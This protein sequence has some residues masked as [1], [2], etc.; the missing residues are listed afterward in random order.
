MAKVLQIL[1]SGLGGHGSVAFSL[2]EGDE[3]KSLDH[4]MLFYGIEELREEY[5][6]K[7]IQYAVPFH[8]VKKKQ[9]IDIN[10]YFKVYKALK[11]FR[12]DVVLM[13]SINLIVVG[14]IYKI[15]NR[16]KLLVVEHTPNQSKRGSEWLWSIL[17]CLFSQK[18]VVLSNSYK[19]EVKEKLGFFYR[20]CKTTVIP[21]GIDLNKFAP[22]KVEVAYN[23]ELYIAMQSRL[24]KTKDH[25]T[26]I[27]AFK[28]LNKGENIVL[29]IAGGGD[30]LEELLI[31][32]KEQA[33]ED[34]AFFTGALNENGIVEFLNNTFIYVH[35]SLS[36]V[37]STSVMQAMAT[38]L[39]IIAS[40]I[41]G[42]NNMVIDGENGLLFPVGNDK[43]LTE[44][45]ELLILN[46][47]LRKRLS[48]NARKYA[49]ANFS[50]EKMF[51]EYSNLFL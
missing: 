12:P 43:I 40:D 5:Q 2:I 44:K 41:P 42:I 33:I 8:S 11:N 39:P 17:G 23:D 45:I 47:A 18:V 49:E 15:F 21:N 13:H 14:I 30:T 38:G 50:N 46:E 27:K 19:Y 25:R 7:C 3:N 4:G 32:V 6:A 48:I 9:G 10:S 24:S 20:D 28:N 31:L 26:L 34:K 1:Y 22:N 37:M 29:K 36:E 51:E 16:C 35:S